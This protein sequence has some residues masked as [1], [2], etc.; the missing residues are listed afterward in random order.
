M[1]SNCDVASPRPRE[2]VGL[3]LSYSVIGRKDSFILMHK[4]L[5]FTI[6][7]ELD[8]HIVCLL[9]FRFYLNAEKSTIAD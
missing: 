8:G 4:V 5:V 3:P 7:D 1:G 6:D 9:S 2:I